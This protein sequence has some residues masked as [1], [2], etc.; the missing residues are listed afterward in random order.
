MF[1]YVKPLSPELKVREHEFYKRVYCAVCH[2]NGKTTGCSSR[3]ALS[4][5]LV[6]LALIRMA[7]T[8]EIPKKAEKRC[9]AHPF[10]RRP[11]LEITPSMQYTARAG[12]L[13]TY[14]NLLDKISDSRGLRRLPPL[15]FR[16]I[17]AIQR[18]RALRGTDGML[19]RSITVALQ[20]LHEIEK[21]AAGDTSPDRAADCFGILLRDLFAAGLAEDSPQARIAAEIGYRTGRWIYLTDAADDLENDR[22]SKS[23]NPFLPIED[24]LAERI[25]C[26]LLCELTQLEKAV[27]LIDFPFPESEAL[28]LNIIYLGMPDAAARAIAHGIGNFETIEQEAAE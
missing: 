6:F 12:A 4:Y 2:A 23:Y 11:T 28:V 18:R 8:G 21:G 24:N 20:K 14:Y 26:A 10:R 25:R 15:L 22:K 17:A 27:A 7:L 16:P 13:L 3:F 1:G 5:D 19:D 9:P